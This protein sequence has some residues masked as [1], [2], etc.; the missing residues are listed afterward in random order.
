[1][2]EPTKI[3]VGETT[4]CRTTLSFISRPHLQ[5]RSKS[6]FSFCFNASF[7]HSNVR[8]HHF[9]Q[10][11]AV[12]SLFSF[13]DDAFTGQRVAIHH[14]ETRSLPG[15]ET[16]IAGNPGCSNHRIMALDTVHP[17]YKRNYCRL[18]SKQEPK[19]AEHETCPLGCYS[20][21]KYEVPKYLYWVVPD[22][23]RSTYPESCR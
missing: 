14:L 7:L 10:I 22:R 15:V 23:L 17:Y 21:R 6:S 3:G 8:F 16:G 2:Y 11:W 20:T 1:M 18:T 12:A 4:R 19:L 5:K 13:L 9:Y